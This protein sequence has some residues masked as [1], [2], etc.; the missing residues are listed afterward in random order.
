MMLV[1]LRTFGLLGLL[2]LAFGL[3]LWSRPKLSTWLNIEPKISVR[4]IVLQEV[5]TPQMKAASALPPEGFYVES[6]STER[7]YLTCTNI[8][9]QERLHIYSLATL[10]T[11]CGPDSLLC[12]PK[13]S[14]KCQL[15]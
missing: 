3:G 9:L 15:R 14:G 8:S 7:V 10:S 12:Y 5:H 1:L 6:S 11:L 13:V 2:L 4:G